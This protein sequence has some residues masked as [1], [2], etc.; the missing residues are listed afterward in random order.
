MSSDNDCRITGENGEPLPGWMVA[1][2]CDADRA[3]YPDGIYAQ[4]RA[5]ARVSSR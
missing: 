3:T 5:M 2:L 4:R 1:F